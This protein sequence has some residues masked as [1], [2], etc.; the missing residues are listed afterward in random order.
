MA[1]ERRVRAAHTVAGRPEARQPEAR[2]RSVDRVLRHPVAAL[3]GAIGTG[4]I[5]GSIA[6][7]P[8]AV[9]GMA[10]GGLAGHLIHR[11]EASEIG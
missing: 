9:V 4:L 1:I 2:P 8:S 5:G 7:L 3:G 11:R 10:I 6:G